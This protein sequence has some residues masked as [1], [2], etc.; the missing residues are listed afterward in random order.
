MDK[1]CY[2]TCSE[3]TLISTNANC[4]WIKPVFI[5]PWHIETVSL[6]IRELINDA[7]DSG[8]SCYKT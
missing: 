8:T 1:Y 5:E 6:S 7:M 2:Y 3:T 4:A